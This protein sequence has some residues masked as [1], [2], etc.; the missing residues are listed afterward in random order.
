MDRYKDIGQIQYGIKRGY[1]T[2]KYPEIPFNEQDT[3]VI[4]TDGDRYDILAQQYYG[5]NSLWW[6]ISIANK[7]LLQNSLLPVPGAQIR[8]P[9]DLNGVLI[10][11]KQ[12]NF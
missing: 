2:V 1:K 6:V 10:A 9:G 7:E 4:C 12:L 3:Y 8:I 5:D 11:Y